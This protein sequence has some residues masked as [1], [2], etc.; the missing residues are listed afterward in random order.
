MK[1]LQIAGEV[2]NFLGD[3]SMNKGMHPGRQRGQ[4]RTVNGLVILR[5]M[6]HYQGLKAGS[7][8][9]GNLRVITVNFLFGICFPASSQHR[10]A[11]I[12]GFSA[13]A[14]NDAVNYRFTGTHQASQ[15]RSS[16]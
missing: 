2:N 14:T 9:P 6:A 11:G 7:E 12:Q 15:R 13:D 8:K 4:I 10:A 1:E 16:I 3:T 5:L